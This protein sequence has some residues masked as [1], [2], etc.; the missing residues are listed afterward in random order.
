LFSLALSCIKILRNPRKIL[1]IIQRSNGDVFL[2][3]SLVKALYEHYESPQIDLLVNDDTYQVASLLPNINYIHTFSYKKKTNN[4]WAQEKEIIMKLFRKY[5]LS[6]N[7]TASDRSVFYA[8]MAGKKSI[9]AV[10]IDKKKSWWKKIFLNHYYYFDNFKHI[11]RN[12]LEPLNLLKINSKN[13]HYDIGV[14]SEA[15]FKIKQKLDA[16]K[17]SDFVIFHPSAQYQ[18]KIFPQYLR[19]ELL[20]NL[21]KLGIS[22]LITGSQNNIDLAIKQELPTLNNVFDFIGETTLEEYFAL[23]E[24]SMA[25]VGMDTLNMHIAASQ[26]KRIFVISGPT[27]L[28][29]WSPWSNQ[30]RRSASFDM[31]IQTYGDISIFQANMK[32]VACGKAGCD[33]SGISKCLNNINPKIVSEEVKEWYKYAGL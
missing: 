27:N 7:L 25:Y 33:D 29:M 17:V 28:K 8:L 19:D 23:S 12:N 2:S 3:S 14:S 30:L 6:I 22:I 21:S 26:N 24:L 5:D 4:R 31:P 9:S 13:I 16:I 1:I 18:Y 10:E 32:C 20:S 15:T 11:L